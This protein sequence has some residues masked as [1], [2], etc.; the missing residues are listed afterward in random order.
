MIDILLDTIAFDFLVNANGEMPQ[1]AKNLIEDSENKLYLSIVSVW[2]MSIQA[3]QQKITYTKPFRDMIREE[4]IKHEIHLIDL[5]LE[6]TH[7]QASMPFLLI[8]GKLHKDPF[9]R[10]IIAQAIRRKLMVI[11]SDTKFPSYPIQVTWNRNA[12]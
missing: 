3:A 4:I 10:M 5:T 7:I 11:S 9:D 12:L 1:A 8:H 6:D 2:E